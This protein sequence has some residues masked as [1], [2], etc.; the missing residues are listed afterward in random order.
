[1]RKFFRA[2]VIGALSAAALILLPANLA[3]GEEWTDTQGKTFKGTAVEALGP[4][5]VF[6]EQPTVGRCLP[7][8][9]L[10]LAELARFS[11]AAKNHPPRADDWAEAKSALTA[12]L[13]GHLEKMQ[14]QKLVPFAVDG[15]PEP[16]V[17][18]MVFLNKDA[19]DTW[20]LLWGSMEPIGKLAQLPPGFVECI[21]Y[22]KNYSPS[23]WLS[24]I[25]DAGAPWSL[26]RID[27]EPALTTLG[28]FVPRKGYRAVAFNRDGVPLFGAFDPDE[29]AVKEFWKKVAGFVAMLEPANPFSWR[30][31]AYL[32]T[33]EKIAA[34]PGGRVEP[35]LIGHAIRPGSLARTNIRAFDATLKVSVDGIVSEVAGLTSEANISPKL[36]EAIV[37]TLKKAVFVPALENGRPVASEFV[38]RFR[39]EKPTAP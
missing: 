17:V 39:D 23:E 38:Y 30:S 31:R 10:P 25:K 16:A 21:A 18:V 24:A 8:Q 29:D 15:R 35:E 19:G 37:T 6:A 33:A 20:K 11:V 7:V 1:M 28:E 36:H 22:G 9:A 27:D 2:S 12:E 5:A 14:Q 34:H 32:R 26:V 4:F 13:R 3:H